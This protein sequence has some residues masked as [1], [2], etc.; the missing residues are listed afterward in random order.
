MTTKSI[1]ITAEADVK[2]LDRLKRQLQEVGKE[3]SKGAKELTQAVSGSNKPG[4]KGGLSKALLEDI[5]TIKDHR[6]ELQE[7]IR[8]LNTTYRRALQDEEKQ[9]DNVIRK[10]KEIERLQKGKQARLDG[11]NTRL[12]FNGEDLTPRQWRKLRG[13]Q[14]MLQRD[15]QGI[16]ADRVAAAHDVAEATRGRYGGS[17]GGGGGAGGAPGTPGG[18]GG[19][20]G[21]LGALPPWISRMIGPAAI[22]GMAMSAVTGAPSMY[23]SMQFSDVH[24]PASWARPFGAMGSS[25]LGGDMSNIL[26]M[27]Q[28]MG[29][30][31]MRKRLSNIFDSKGLDII[32]A[33]NQGSRWNPIKFA[34]AMKTLEPQK[35]EMFRGLVEDAKAIGWRDQYT[36]GAFQSRAPGRL[37]ALRAYG[38]GGGTVDYYDAQG[39]RHTSNGLRGLESAG[40]GMGFMPEQV[41][42]MFQGAM[43]SAGRAGARKI[44]ETIMAAVVSG[45]DQGTATAIASSVARG[46][47]GK[48]LLRGFT[49]LGSGTMDVGAA[50]ALGAFAGQ[51][52]VSTGLGAMSGLGVAGMLSA[53]SWHNNEADMLAASQR[54]AGFGAMGRLTTGSVDS[55]QRAQNLVNAM[56]VLGGG[57]ILGA[58][59]LATM[60]PGALMNIMAGEKGTP[61]ARLAA[62]Y[63]INQ[64]NASQ[65][66][67]QMVSGMAARSLNT[68]GTDDVSLVSKAIRGGRSIQDIIKNG[69]VEGVKDV[70]AGVAG[71]LS[72]SFGMSG[73]EAF[74]FI[75]NMGHAGKGFKAGK[76]RGDGGAGSPEQKYMVEMAKIQ[77]Q[78]IKDANAMEEKIRS[79]AANMETFAKV[80]DMIGKRGGE[81]NMAEAAENLGLFSD[82]VNTAAGAAFSFSKALGGPGAAPAK[83]AA[84]GTS[85][86]A[87]ANQ[88]I[89]AAIAKSVQI[90]HK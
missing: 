87:A 19:V 84:A 40:A 20:N 9:Y 66:F 69:G 31:G 85:P 53:G 58:N 76:R 54:M 83:A 77:D 46:G 64:K 34:E 72:S 26:A 7:T 48:A 68:G 18:G 73:D 24:V 49:S 50:G 11:I 25:A 10:L 33:S 8:F 32:D 42:G 6:K 61:G 21:I 82:A 47:A 88:R 86:A 67:D 89:G 59:R 22:A 44:T 17:G 39:N 23:R 65:Y 78:L 4:A 57:N 36:F 90:V 15:L 51:N 2:G 3:A 41:H 29:T 13:R 52:G 37:S 28:L 16:E 74:G 35:A 14:A 5:K 45:I 27:N 60:D 12:E 81:G 43:A 71:F 80:M 55:Y 75:D 62:A 63:G 1:K 56:G 70:R 38:G 79:I 30:A